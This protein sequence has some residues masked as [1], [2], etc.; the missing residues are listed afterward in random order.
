[1]RIEFTISEIDKLES[2]L[3]NAVAD[4][5]AALRSGEM[6]PEKHLLKAK[7]IVEG[8]VS[9]AIRGKEQCD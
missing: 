2:E 1:M 3:L 5:M 9:A 6:S 8:F 4:D 7:A